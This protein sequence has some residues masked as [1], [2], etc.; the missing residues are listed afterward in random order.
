MRK[1][2]VA[3]ITL[4]AGGVPVLA[5]SML[6]SSCGSDR[7]PFGP[8]TSPDRDVAP[9]D[10]V[11][12][13][14]APAEDAVPSGPY[15]EVFQT[16]ELSDAGDAATP[17]QLCAIQPSP[18]ATTSAARITLKSYSPTQRTAHGF[19]SMPSD[20]EAAVV[21]LPSIKVVYRS[22]SSVGGLVVTDMKRVLGGYEFS[23]Q[24]PEALPNQG[25]LGFAAMTLALEFD[26]ACDVDD[27]AT[28][29][30]QAH[31]TLVL[32]DT[33]DGGVEWVSAG[34]ECC[35]D[36]QIIAEMAPSPIVSDKKKDDLPLARVVRL[37]VL[38]LARAGRQVLLFAENDAGPDL[39]IEW[40]VSGGSV[41][42]IAPDLMLWTLPGDDSAPFGQV[43]VWNDAGAA[44]ENF[45]WGIA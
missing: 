24:W 32:C 17:E 11:G 25:C 18:A 34:D 27:A 4:A 15:C 1:L 22:T 37:R 2:R 29:T 33:V 35:N 41:E 5:V 42:R 7:E 12:F 9:I 28:K 36:C 23:A 3:V 45:V 20:V 40:S 16:F 43:A 13:T 14:P 6:A 21:G 10:G 31:T 26:I 44:V 38:E 8:A 30:V 19:V 39:A